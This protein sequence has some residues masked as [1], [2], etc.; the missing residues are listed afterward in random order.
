MPNPNQTYIVVNFRQIQNIL[1]RIAAEAGTEGVFLVDESGFLIAE[2]GDISIDR[3]A[4]S[5]LLAASFGATEEVARLLGENGFE[6][7]IHQGDKRHL[8]ICKAGQRHI[9]ISIFNRSTNLGLVKLYVERAVVHLSAIMDYQPPELKRTVKSTETT[10]E[11]LDEE[12]EYEIAIETLEEKFED[13]TDIDSETDEQTSESLDVDLDDDIITDIIEESEEE[14][15][16]I[17]EDDELNK[18]MED[19]DDDITKPGK[20]IKFELS[21]IRDESEQLENEIATIP[22]DEEQESEGTDENADESEEQQTRKD[23]E[24]RDIPP[25]LEE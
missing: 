25:W 7:L 1:D 8:F 11:M 15:D 12:N 10:Q 5:A 17:D 24:G 13:D 20:D 19:V 2:A 23:D 22:S 16:I 21:Q 4:L 14:D 3:I 9:V 6:E 18:E